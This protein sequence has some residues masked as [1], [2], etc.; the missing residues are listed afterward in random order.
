MS[1]SLSTVALRR[2][3]GESGESR[4][5][6]TA[7]LVIAQDEDQ[8][9]VLMEF[10]A[11]CRRRRGRTGDVF[12]VRHDGTLEN[13]GAYQLVNNGALASR[14]IEPQRSCMVINVDDHPQAST[15]LKRNFRNTLKRSHLRRVELGEPE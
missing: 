15:G 1:Q 5:L 2:P 6:Y 14:R 8:A 9:S 3:G 13:S 11:A 12:C 10:A 4:A 7:D